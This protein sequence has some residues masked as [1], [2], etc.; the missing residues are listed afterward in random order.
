MAVEIIMQ[1]IQ[2]TLLNPT[3]IITNSTQERRLR[4]KS[5][6]GDEEVSGFAAIP[7]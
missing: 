1:H 6:G 5:F 7:N 2:D 4:G 3:T